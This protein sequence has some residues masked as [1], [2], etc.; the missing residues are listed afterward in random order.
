[1]KLLMTADTVGG[2]WTYALELVRA[3]EPRGVEIALATMG[4]PMNAA[5]RAEAGRLGNLRVHESTFRLEWMESPWDDVRRAGEWLLE[6]ADRERPDVVHLNGYAHG[7]LPWPAPVVMVGHSCVRSWWEAVKGTP[8]PREWD[9]YTHRVRCGLHAADLVVAPSRA[10]LD[11]LERHYGL[12]RGGCVILNGRELRHTGAAAK[13]HIVL[14]AGRLWD[15]AKNLQALDRVSAALPWPVYLAGSTDS[16]DGHRRAY[17]ASR[18]L[19]FLDTGSLAGWMARA[20]IYALPARYE[21]FGLTV[22]EAAQAG[23]ALV[24]GDIP[25]L[26]ELWDDAALY[27]RPDDDAALVHGIRR[28][29]DDEPLRAAMAARAR[30][31]AADLTPQRMA[32]RYC[33]A[34][35]ALAGRVRH[36]AREV[37]CAS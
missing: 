20:S 31:R 28:L 13:E 3:L 27:V 16:P 14:A 23:C 8:V 5:Q 24:L 11:A 26:R 12:A 4:A 34:Y 19:G 36:D 17:G 2:V 32:D 33:S 29:C 37:L 6:L 9:E 21:P 7:D 22:L 18:L 15:D 30:R 1:M 25:S 10:M 35:R